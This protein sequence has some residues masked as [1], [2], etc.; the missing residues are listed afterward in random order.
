MSLAMMLNV[1]S[2]ISILFII[3]VGL[4]IIFGLMGVVN[5]AH[6]EFIMLGA[7]ASFITVHL[8]MSPWLAFLLAP[9]LVGV[10]GF[11]TEKLL[12]RHLYGKIMESILAT[13]GLAII[14][15]QVVEWVFGKGFK[16]IT[17]PVDTSITILGAHYPLYRLIIICIAVLLAISLLIIEKKTNLGVIVKAVIANPS[18]AAALGVNVNKVYR[19]T[20]VVGAAL[21]GFAGAIIAPIVSVYPLMGLSY[22][23]NAFL[24]VLV[25]GVGALTGLAGSASLL[26]GS[27]SLLSFWLDPT[28]GSICVVLLSVLVIRLRE[29][30]M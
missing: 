26:G 29:S 22:V 8:G 3:A 12:I 1:I 7:Y 21:A 6:G 19:M 15:R 9:L 4:Y 11:L 5:L 17:P 24:A 25:S 20:F 14:I 30:K 28:W 16:P 27:E 10:V 13:W 23:I 2:S 18:L